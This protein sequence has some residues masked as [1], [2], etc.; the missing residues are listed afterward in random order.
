MSPHD[1]SNTPTAVTFSPISHSEIFD[2]FAVE[3][4]IPLSESR[5]ILIQ[6][7]LPRINPA[8]VMNNIKSLIMINPICYAWLGDS[9][10]RLHKH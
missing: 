5:F 10:Q 2:H 4:L 7:T 6:P 3:C 1:Q 9:A 8:M